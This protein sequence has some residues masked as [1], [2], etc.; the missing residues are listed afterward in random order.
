MP[1]VDEHTNAQRAEETAEFGPCKC[2][3]EILVRMHPSLKAGIKSFAVS[4]G[5]SVNLFVRRVLFAE[6]RRRKK[7]TDD[8]Q[9][10]SQ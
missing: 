1:K 6:Y 8:L 2:I 5:I 4:E 7:A 3:D 10:A 9:G